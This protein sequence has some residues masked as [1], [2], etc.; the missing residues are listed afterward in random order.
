M[1]PFVPTGGNGTVYLLAVD[2]DYVQT[3]SRVLWN[4]SMNI[5]RSLK[6]KL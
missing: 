5:P 4:Q 1:Y 6:G 2:L 3:S